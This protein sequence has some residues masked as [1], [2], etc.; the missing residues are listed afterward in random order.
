MLSRKY[1]LSLQ[2]KKRI[3]IDPFFFLTFFIHLYIKK[4][5]ETFHFNLTD[6]F[7]IQLLFAQ[8]IVKYILTQQNSLV[9]AKEYIISKGVGTVIYL[10]QS[11]T[12]IIVC[13]DQY[14]AIYFQR[15]SRIE[16]LTNNSKKKENGFP[17]LLSKIPGMLDL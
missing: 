11:F 12:G 4:K 5:L 6:L 3:R 17:R 2:T 7:K 9:N 15:N 13:S 10:C 14:V 8:L 16:S 1:T